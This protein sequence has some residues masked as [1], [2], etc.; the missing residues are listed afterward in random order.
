MMFIYYLLSSSFDYVMYVTKFGQAC[1]CY[2]LLHNVVWCQ[3][4]CFDIYLKSE[5]PLFLENLVLMI[6]FFYVTFSVKG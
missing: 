2:Y 5:I 6:T 1:I 4:L 3:T